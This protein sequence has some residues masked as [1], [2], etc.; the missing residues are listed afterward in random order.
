LITQ[1][2]SVLSEP[3]E[4]PNEAV[5]TARKAFKRLRALYRLV[6]ADAPAFRASENARFRDIA[7]GLS[8]TRDAT[9]L[10]ETTS[11][12]E[13]HARS[14]RELEALSLVTKML[15]Q[16]RDRIVTDNTGIDANISAAIRECEAGLCALEALSLPARKKAVAKQIGR[17]WRKQRKAAIKAIAHCRA[18]ASGEHFHELRKCGQ[19]YWMHLSLLR[20]LWPSAM[21]AKSADAKQ[22][23]D[24]LGHEHD[25]SILAAFADRQ[26]ESFPDGETLARLL[27]AIIQRQLALRQE[28]LQL[29][30]RIFREDARTESRIVMALWQRAAR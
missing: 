26:P 14:D 6:Q 30:D 13:Q 5:H 10:V 15:M 18:D 3:S 8:A 1:A 16:R 28:G 2:I 19:T 27:G 20:R 7:R 23:V 29:A 21:R 22:L 17:A 4:G 9:A 24:L 11:Y 12:L 25:L